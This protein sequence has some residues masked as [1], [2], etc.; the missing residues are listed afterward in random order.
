MP[1]KNMDFPGP[2]VRIPQ[3][4]GPRK[5]GTMDTKPDDLESKGDKSTSAGY[6]HDDV[7]STSTEEPEGLKSPVIRDENR[8]D[9]G[10]RYSLQVMSLPLTAKSDMEEE[11]I[12]RSYETEVE[13]VL[14]KEEIPENY[15]QYIKNYF[16]S[17]GMAE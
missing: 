17:I 7:G 12:L 13:S 14:N 11:A 4:E 6:G 15:R 1:G 2:L 3:M 16:L 10:T 9:Q 8:S 5:P